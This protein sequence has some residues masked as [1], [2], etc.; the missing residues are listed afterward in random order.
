MDGRGKL[1]PLVKEVL[2]L[3]QARLAHEKLDANAIVG[4][5]ALDPEA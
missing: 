4:K 5:L 2:P 3:S 1:A